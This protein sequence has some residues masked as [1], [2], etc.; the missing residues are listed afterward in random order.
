M[1]MPAKR[2]RSRLDAAE[3]RFFLRQLEHIETE[4]YEHMFPEI[5]Y[6]RLIP[7]RNGYDPGAVKH[8]YRMIEQIGRAKVITDKSQRIPR[9]DVVGREEAQ[10]VRPIA[11]AF[12]YSIYEIKGASKAGISLES[13]RAI[14]A[15][16]AI[17]RELESIAFLGDAEAGLNGLCTHPDI[18]TANVA[19]GAGGA[20]WEDKTDDEI[21]ADMNRPVE[22]I[23]TQ[24]LGIHSPDTLLLPESSFTLVAQRRLQDQTVT[25]LEFFLRSNP[26]ISSVE[27]LHWLETAGAANTKRM[28]AYRRDRRMVELN[29]PHG[30]EQLEPEK[31]GLEY[32]SI[33]HMS[34]AGVIVRY[35]RAA[36]YQDGF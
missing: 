22:T 6:A 17:E 23:R 9:V 7:T 25:I 11:D 18:N 30:L 15:R 24:T 13:E 31:K 19:N 29:N 36:Q 5:K 35:P 8:L 33:M 28:V 12:G 2:E 34:T 3:S 16:E 1:N 4:V 32:E 26:F 27:P 21:L 14:T 10:F 20:A